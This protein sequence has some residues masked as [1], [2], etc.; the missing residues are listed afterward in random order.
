[1]RSAAG[2]RGDREVLAFDLYGTLVD[3]IA[4]SSE[5][6]QVLGES[7][8]RE[9]ARLWRLKQ[10]EYS[11]RLTAME[12]Y[13]D[14]RWVTSR[15]LDFALAAIGVSLPDGHARRLVELYDHLP[16][17]PDAI[18]ALQTLA[19]SG[20]ELTVLSNGS[21]AMIENCLGN[22]GLGDFFRQRISADE[23]R[24]FKPSPV[25]YRHAAE[26]LARPIAR[27]RL[28]TCNAFDSAGA[29]AA[30]MLTAWVNRSGVPFDTIGRQP[31]LTVPA[32]DR[33]PAAL[34]SSTR[35]RR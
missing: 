25:V 22:S 17:F 9:T 11:F 7:D 12:H 31:D 30:G 21:P 6:D 24:V 10:L 20:H 4:I 15:A 34:A 23:V 13:E 19:D 32:L 33:L 27:I 8:G 3:P 16:P 35:A 26:R 1:V 5:L 2:D 28:V 18:P 14:F 29:S